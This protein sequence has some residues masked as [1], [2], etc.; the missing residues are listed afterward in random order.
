MELGEVRLPCDKRGT[1]DISTSDC[2]SSMVLVK[3]INVK[4]RLGVGT[5]LRHVAL[6]SAD[7]QPHEKRA[8]GTSLRSDP[9]ICSVKP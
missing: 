1:R 4:N 7:C 6:Q 3:L 5:C 8:K 9:A 2:V